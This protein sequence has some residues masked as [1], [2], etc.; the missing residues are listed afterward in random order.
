MLV[1]LSVENLAVVEKVRVRF[2]GGFNVLSGETGSG[3]SIVVDALNLL[4]GGRASGDMVRSGA[5][6]MRVSG[7]FDL[8]DSSAALRAFLDEAG[9][10]TEDR[11]LILEREIAANTGKSRAYAGGKPV[12]AS[13][14]RDLSQY[15]GSIHGQHDQQG[16]SSPEAQR[17][18]LDAVS[19]GTQKLLPDV[20]KLH[21]AYRAIARELD[22]LDRNEQEKLRMAD[23]WSFQKKEIEAAELSAGED[24]RLEAERKILRNVTRVEESAQAAFALLYDA[25]ESA[26]TQ[27]KQALKKLED[28]ARIDESLQA[29][30]DV[31]RPGIFS[32]DEASQSL[33]DYLGKL[34]ADPGRLDTVESRLA[35]IEKLKRKYGDSLD[36]VLTFLATVSSQLEAVETAGERRAALQKDKE[37]IAAEYLAAAEALHD[38]RREGARQLVKKV[39]AELATLAMQ[40]TRFVVRIDPAAEWT[41][42]GIDDIEFLISANVGED[43]KPLDKVASGGE[44]SRVSLALKTIAAGARQRNEAAR[45]MVFDEVDAGVSG[46]AAEAVG[47]KLRR[48]A[49]H[50]QVLCVTHLP[51]V[52]SFA[53][54]HFSVSKHASRNRT[55]T[56]IEELDN[57][58]RTREIGRMLSGERLT[59]EALRQAEQ[60]IQFASAA[61]V[62]SAAGKS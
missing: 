5:D 8:G 57:D 34:E 47:R 11:E 42:H 18:L 49:E 16:L 23:L 38:K 45:T 35:T 62:A 17:E 10:E 33:A 59:D 54:S 28:L 21:A 7:I 19:T 36:D 4:F 53:E 40:R 31:L 12:T 30:A 2:H 22:D 56:T 20:A 37:R 60:L 3:K 51:Q 52:A 9:V 43:P 6:R 29:V 25:P 26:L 48:I 61:S 44:L 50:D 15:L 1:E 32:I 41:S 55:F 27:A 24:T 39:E 13:F 46:K 14:L 58:G